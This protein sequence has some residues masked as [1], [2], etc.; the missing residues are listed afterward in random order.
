MNQLRSS[1][2]AEAVIAILFVKIK[3]YQ[4]YTVPFCSKTKT[5]T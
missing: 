3:I 4:E 2:L 1:N 5:G